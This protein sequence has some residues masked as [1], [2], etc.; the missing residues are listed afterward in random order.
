MAKFPR[1]EVKTHDH[2]TVV[3]EEGGVFSEYVEQA[4]GTR[5]VATVDWSVKGGLPQGQVS[6]YKVLTDDG[7]EYYIITNSDLTS[8][9]VVTIADNVYEAVQSAKTEFLS[10]ANKYLTPEEK[11]EQVKEINRLFDELLSKAPA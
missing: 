3:V 9:V 1:L 8:D 6:L 5:K 4:L 10:F 11:E 2:N 7:K